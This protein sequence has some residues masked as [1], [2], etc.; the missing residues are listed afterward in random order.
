MYGFED[1]TYH[2]CATGQ[3]A[4]AIDKE[5]GIK[6]ETTGT[7]ES[8]MWFATPPSIGKKIGECAWT[9]PEWQKNRGTGYSQGAPL[10]CPRKKQ[11][12][13]SGRGSAPFW[14]CS[15]ECVPGSGKK[16]NEEMPLNA[17]IEEGINALSARDAQVRTVRA[18]LFQDLAEILGEP[19]V[20]VLQ[21]AIVA[22]SV[23]DDDTALTF[24][25]E[26]EHLPTGPFTLG[27]EVM[28]ASGPSV[29][30]EVHWFIQVGSRVGYFYDRALFDRCLATVV[31]RRNDLLRLDSSISLYGFRPRQT[32]TRNLATAEE[33]Q[34]TPP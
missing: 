32:L 14:E 28:M 11:A 20:L 3:Q 8:A 17:H 1:M 23:S 27:A 2:R 30:D 25:F 13:Q 10:A 31:T 18:R 22:E 24:R 7:R 34:G 4:R 21:S 6:D 33:L 9:A 26:I 19:A 15:P 29:M 5:A 12:E 16:G